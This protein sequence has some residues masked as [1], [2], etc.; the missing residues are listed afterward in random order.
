MSVTGFLFMFLVAKAWMEKR[1][2]IFRTPCH[3]RVFERNSKV[4]KYI[5]K[6][7]RN[8]QFMKLLTRRKFK[9]KFF[10]YQ[11]DEKNVLCYADALFVGTSPYHDRKVVALLAVQQ[12]GRNKADYCLKAACSDKEYKGSGSRLITT[13]FS[14][15]RAF[16]KKRIWLHA[17]DLE[18][19]NIWKRYGFCTTN[20]R[21]SYYVKMRKQLK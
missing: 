16:G 11:L 10:E 4:P 6:Q 12:F 1:K 18:A 21:T 15:A 17:V 8:S 19:A 2:R 3:V 20:L 7:L 9:A 5:S 14:R 13:F